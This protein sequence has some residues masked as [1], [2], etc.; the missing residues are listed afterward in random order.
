MALSWSSEAKWFVFDLKGSRFESEL[1]FQNQE[2][3]NGPMAVRW[4]IDYESKS[5]YIY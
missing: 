3:E 1:I 4:G 2:K 5:D